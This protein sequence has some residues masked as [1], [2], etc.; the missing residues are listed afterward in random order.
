LLKENKLDHVNNFLYCL[1]NSIRVITSLL[2]PIL[3]KGTKLMVQQL[4]LTE[5]QLSFDNL[6]NFDLLND[7]K[8]NVSTPIYTRIETKNS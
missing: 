1:G 8:V 3:T 2:Q 7:H 6:I 5:S 4:G